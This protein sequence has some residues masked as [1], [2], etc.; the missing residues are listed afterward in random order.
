MKGPSTACVS[1][2]I[3][4]KLWTA[5]LGDSRAIL[6]NPKTGETMALS[7]DHKGVYYEEKIRERSGFVTQQHSKTDSS[8]G[9][10]WQGGMTAEKVHPSLIKLPDITRV[11]LEEGEER[12]LVT[13]CD[14]MFDE[15]STQQ[16]GEF[17]LNQTKAGVPPDQLIAKAMAATAMVSDDDLSLG[18]MAIKMNR[19]TV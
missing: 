3:G 12:I 16:L 10:G 1:L 6:V 14:G 7:A 5:N 2:L 19:K 17:V 4:N 11:E 9:A 8:N 18:L 15:A 13:G